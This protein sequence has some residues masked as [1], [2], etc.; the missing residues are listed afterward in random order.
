MRA[1]ST[2]RRAATRDRIVSAAIGVIAQ[3]GVQGA[4]V[5]EICEAAGFTRG[6]FYSNFDDKGEL[7]VAIMEALCER[8]LAAAREGSERMGRGGDDPL[9]GAIA[10]FI[11]ATGETANAVLVLNEMRLQAAREPELRASF[12][13]FDTIVNPLFG[14]VIGQALKANGLR[15]RVPIDEATALLHAT[16]TQTTLDLLLRGLPPDSPETGQR[17][18]GLL[19]TLL[20]DEGEA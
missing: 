16:Y 8:Y 15:L 5:E 9:A 19:R 1:T 17:L 20:A 2:P 14:E 18:L 13:R 4:S 3:R 11:H 10:T 6:A 12:Q 7:Y